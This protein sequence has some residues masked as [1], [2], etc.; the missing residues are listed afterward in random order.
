[1]DGLECRGD[2]ALPTAILLLA[3]ALALPAALLGIAAGQPKSL[4]ALIAPLAAAGWLAARRRYRLILR[5]DRLEQLTWR[6]RTV[7]PCTT[8]Q[9]RSAFPQACGQRAPA[10][11]AP[12]AGWP[13]DILSSHRH[14]AQ[15][16]PARHGGVLPS[17]D[18]SP[19]PAH[20]FSDLTTWKRCSRFSQ[21]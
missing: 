5:P 15:P 9:R 3:G 4:L 12:A 16:G 18:R 20:F 21:P 17:G 14:S 11:P 6:G 13:G 10:L 8:P 7:I 2:T 19:A 1:M